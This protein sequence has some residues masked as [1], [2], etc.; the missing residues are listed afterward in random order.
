MPLPRF[1]QQVRSLLRDG[2][3]RT[4]AGMAAELECSE[5]TIRRCADYLRNEEGWPLEAGKHGYVLREPT[6]AESQVTS[7]SDIAALAMAYVTL[8]GI[9]EI[10][11]G[12]RIRAEI[13]RACR[14]ADDLGGVRW[15]TLDQF[16][17]HRGA[18]GDAAGDL[19]IHGHLTLAILNRQIIRIRY[20]RI[21]DEDSFTVEVYPHR[22]IN[23]DQCW[24]LIAADFDLGG[25]KAY[26]APRI[27][28]VHPVPSRPGFLVPEFVDHYAHA[29]GI[30]TPFEPDGTL[31]EVS[32]ELQGYWARVAL[33]R[34]WHPSQTLEILAPDRVRVNFRVNELVE[35]KSWV[36]RL[37][38]LPG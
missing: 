30:W 22:L 10:D 20:R 12:I 17:E 35:V 8:R 21:E 26:A 2:K 38:P 9:G 14:H 3:V 11:L 7:H 37:G 27:S 1:L 18:T 34:R 24:Y 19:R 5:R 25:Q 13:A 33:E 16:V 23:R 32:V 15:E 4:A 28:E 31:H 6:V 29:F 36:L